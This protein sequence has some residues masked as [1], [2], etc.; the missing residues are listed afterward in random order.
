VR[1]SIVFNVLVL[2]T[3]L[4]PALRAQDRDDA[5][6]S[7]SDVSTSGVNLIAR[8][9]MAVNYKSGETTHIDIRGTDLMPELTGT[10]K[11]N[12]KSGLT[13]I[14]VDVENFRPAHDIDVAYLTY[15]L[16]TVSPQGQAKNVGELVLK[17]KKASLH[18][19]TNLQAFALVITA[20]PDFAVAQPSE[21]VVGENS[22]RSTTEGRPESVTAR[23][24]VFPR[25]VY[26]SQ[27]T[28]AMPDT[29]R[30][31]EHAPLDL[32]EA[33]NAVRIARD[34]HADEYATDILRRAE[35]L[36]NEAEDYYRGN[37]GK[38]SVGTAAREAV[39]TAEEARVNSIHAEEQARLEH[40]RQ[41]NRERTAQAQAQ[42][43]QSQEDARR[44]QEQA[45]REAQQRA[46]AEQQ[47]QQAAED[48]ERARQRAQA[49]AD[50][51]R[52]LEEQQQVAAQQA[53]EAQQQAQHAQEQ[54]QAEAE[55]RAAAEQQN[56]QIAQQAEDA[57]R[58]A[59]EAR[60]RAQQAESQQ[61]E[62]RQR[63]RNQLN[64]ILETR[65]SARGLI[66]SMPDVL[67]DT[68]SANLKP[69]ARERLAKVAGI[70][71]A[72]PDMRI[73][74]DGYTDS[75]GN[76]LFN[77][78][79]SQER[80]ASVQSYLSQQN[81]SPSSISIHGFG[82]ANPIASND[83]AAGRQQNRR[84]ELVVSGQSIGITAQQMP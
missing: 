7:D 72:Y 39:Q 19:T 45:D 4:A 11:I 6:R 3:L 84:V 82:E 57:R 42:S 43:E 15:V 58:Q 76:P 22:I 83:S 17:D 25:S 61:A 10:A 51:R 66:V 54:A 26:V 48:A 81:V 71:L 69:T 46:A 24:Q 56:Q 53:Q 52:Q 49:E 55:H 5:H 9:T 47:S 63:L 14:H 74:V 62:L 30:P 60:Q 38:K 29:Y 16:W 12:S 70:L 13:D 34:A 36:L 75:T 68:G 32:L 50:R 37:H 80:A 67:F 64:E 73:E 21:L 20:E 79:L 23:Y 28:P 2:I 59:D 44:A 1:K 41:E 40:E 18:T 35:T 78:R 27:V 65:D 33:R 8:T 31:D 77:E